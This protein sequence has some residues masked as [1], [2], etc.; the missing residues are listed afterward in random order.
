ML[1]RALPDRVRQTQEISSASAGVARRTRINT[2]LIMAEASGSSGGI[3]ARLVDERGGG[4]W[5]VVLANML[6]LQGDGIFQTVVEY[7]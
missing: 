4:D 1:C 7:L 3:E 2:K 6:G 5:P